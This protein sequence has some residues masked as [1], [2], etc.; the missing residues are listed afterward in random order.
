MTPTFYSALD[1]DAHVARPRTG[2][3]DRGLAHAERGAERAH[4]E[5][6][7]VYGPFAHTVLDDQVKRQ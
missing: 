4:I 2:E 3:V 1:I 6:A 7:Q 5:A